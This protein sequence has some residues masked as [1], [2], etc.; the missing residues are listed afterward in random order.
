MV[1]IK[2][3]YYLMMLNIFYIIIINIISLILLYIYILISFIIKNSLLKYENLMGSFQ[4]SKYKKY[5]QFI[6]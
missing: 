1:G 2:K 3:N 6:F 5:Y 4:K